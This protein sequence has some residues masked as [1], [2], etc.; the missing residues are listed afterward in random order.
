MVT[1]EKKQKVITIFLYMINLGLLLLSLF[2][3]L[4][5]PFLFDAPGSTESAVAWIMFAFVLSMPIVIIVLS[6]YSII[7]FIRK[8][9]MEKAL[10]IAM[11]PGL[12]TLFTFI[13]L[14]LI[15]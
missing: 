10:L 1:K 3:V 11:V 5:T 12:Y 4:M 6:V 13:V 2:G 15:G 9:D 7:L 8:K 14:R